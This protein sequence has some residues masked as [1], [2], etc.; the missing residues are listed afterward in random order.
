MV[1]EKS[2]FDLDEP[3]WIADDTTT[4]C[5]YCKQAFSFFNRR[6]H[7]RRCGGIFCGSCSNNFPL[8]RMGFI[9]PVRVCVNCVPK[10]KQENTFYQHNLKLLVK[11]ASFTLPLSEDPGTVYTCHL[12][13]N[14]YQIE[15]SP[16]RDPIRLKG[17]GEMDTVSEEGEG[18]VS[19]L[20]VKH[21][22][23]VTVFKPHLETKKESAEWLK[24]LKKALII[25]HSKSE[26][27]ASQG[28]SN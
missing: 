6:H 26:T 2:L 19:Q 11:G 7:C 28:Q 13:Q 10:C 20:Q 3:K 27:P 22:N 16:D 17:I 9:D 24:S 18:K 14:H 12:S 5:Q 23:G 4:T 25:L 8:P 21:Q 15:F 1:G